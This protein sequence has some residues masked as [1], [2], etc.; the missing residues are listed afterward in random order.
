MG[1]L[2]IVAVGYDHPDAIRLTAEVQA[3]YVQRYGGPDDA[4]IDPDDFRA[5]EGQF[6]LGYCDGRPV[7]MGGWRRHPV[8]HRQTGWAAPAAEV[9]RMYVTADLRG[10]GFARA[11]L[12]ELERTAALAGIRWLVLETGTMQPEAIALY[13]SAGYQAIPA[14]GYYADAELSVH[15]GKQ[16][17]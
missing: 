7:A 8:E 11:V 4:P 10:A 5:P 15:L 17:G 1:E 6:L 2:H 14:F 9:K 12:A 13:H 16:V 3:E